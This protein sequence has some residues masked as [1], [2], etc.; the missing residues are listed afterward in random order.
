MY[1][2]NL[3]TEVLKQ[4]VVGGSSVVYAP[5]KL[6]HRRVIIIESETASRDES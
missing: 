4:C 2:N 1:V 6:V 3:L 5:I